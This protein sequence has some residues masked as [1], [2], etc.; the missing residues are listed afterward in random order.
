MTIRPDDCND[1]VDDSFLL[2]ILYAL[3]MLHVKWILKD[4]SYDFSNKTNWCYCE[5]DIERGDSDN[6]DDDDDT[7]DS[8]TAHP[9]SSLDNLQRIGE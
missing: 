5:G 6:D 3:A 1:H 4:T 9:C 8:E 2:L 7:I